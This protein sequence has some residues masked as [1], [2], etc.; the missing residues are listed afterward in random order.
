MVA[1]RRTGSAVQE[2]APE[3]VVGADGF[4]RGSIPVDGGHGFARRRS[5]IDTERPDQELRLGRETSGGD[6]GGARW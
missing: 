6:G 2:R 4:L 3:G 1:A 5:W